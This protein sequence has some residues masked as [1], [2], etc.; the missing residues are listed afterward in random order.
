MRLVISEFELEY[1]PCVVRVYF[2]L[3][4]HQ[5]I[6]KFFYLHD[7]DMNEC[8]N[9]RTNP[10]ED[11]CVNTEGGFYCECSLGTRLASDQHSCTGEQ[12]ITS[13]SFVTM[14]SRHEAIPLFVCLSVCQ[15]KYIVGLSVC[16]SVGQKVF[17]EYTPAT[18]SLTSSFLL[19]SILSLSLSKPCSSKY[20]G[21][22]RAV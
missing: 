14:C 19:S 17:H 21:G 9:P 18:S 7:P 4:V 20:R 15:P 6:L 22:G 11:I 10:C 8:A 16:L 5:V 13:F 2:I 3:I 12:G 1:V